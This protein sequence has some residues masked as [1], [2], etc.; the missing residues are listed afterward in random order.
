MPKYIGNI[1]TT[2][3]TEPT[4]NFQDSVAQGVWTLSEA[5]EYIK[6]DIWPTAGN[7]RPIPKGSLSTGIA[8]TEE[9]SNS[10]HYK[11]EDGGLTWSPSGVTGQGFGGISC[12]NAFLNVGSNL[13]KYFSSNFS[14]ENNMGSGS[15]GRYFKSMSGTLMRQKSNNLQKSLDNGITWVTKHTRSPTSSFSNGFHYGNGV[16]FHSYADT[17]ASPRVNYHLVSLDDGET[18][19]SSGITGLPSDMGSGFGGNSIYL[20]GAHYFISHNNTV[21]TS[22]NGLTWS[23]LGSRQSPH[24]TSVYGQSGMIFYRE[25]YF[26]GISGTTIN[27]SSNFGSGWTALGNS[28][29]NSSG[30][31][32]LG[33]INGNWIISSGPDTV[34]TS[35]YT[36]SDDGSTWTTRLTASFGRRPSSVYGINQYDP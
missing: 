1:I 23:I 25:P 6:A 11:T 10:I 22:T 29:P 36:S 21:Y 26:Y 27:R 4:E 31:G 24:I 2:N 14:I 33:Y 9:G 13:N 15:T 28:V 20:N 12:G 3:P 32:R 17:S 8:E 18:W 35:I 5:F 30:T 19:T 16:W 34:T 7:E